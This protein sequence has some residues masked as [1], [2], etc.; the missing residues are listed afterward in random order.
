MLKYAALKS[1]LFPKTL[2]RVTEHRELRK[3]GDKEHAHFSRFQL[4]GHRVPE[5]KEDVRFRVL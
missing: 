2:L 4:G 1:N 3:L 5:E